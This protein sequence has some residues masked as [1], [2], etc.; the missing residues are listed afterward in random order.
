VFISGGLALSGWFM[1]LL[2]KQQKLRG[3]FSPIENQKKHSDII[4]DTDN[5][6]K[7]DNNALH[8]R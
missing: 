7:K 2:E 1:Y 4:T 3:M 6:V 8:I 5:N